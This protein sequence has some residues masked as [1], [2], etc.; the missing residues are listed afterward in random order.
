[1]I[2]ANPAGSMNVFFAG[3]L[4]L[5]HPA[6]NRGVCGRLHFC[7]YQHTI[8]LSIDLFFAMGEGYV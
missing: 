3:F 2:A 5:P 8:S 7:R 4:V 6:V 1:M